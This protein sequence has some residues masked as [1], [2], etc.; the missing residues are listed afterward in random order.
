MNSVVAQDSGDGGSGDGGDSGDGGSGDGGDSG[1]GGSGDSGDGGSEPTP[2]PPE[3]PEGPEGGDGDGGE[4]EEVIVEVVNTA[5]TLSVP[6]Q[7]V[8]EDAG[9][10][11]NLIDLW[12]YV[13]D[14]ISTAANMVFSLVSQTASSVVSCSLDSNRYMDCATQGNQFGTSDVT[15]SVTDEGGLTSQDTFTID[16]QSVNDAPTVNINEPGSKV[17]EN[18]DFNF[19]A[20]ASDVEGDALTYTID[21]DDGT[22]EQGSVVSGTIQTTHRYEDEGRFTITITVSDGSATGSD[23]ITVKTITPISSDIHN[24]IYM[25][26]IAFDNEFVRPGD[27]LT[28]FLNFENQGSEDLKDVRITA[29]IQD[30]GVRSRTLSVDVN[31]NNGV[32]RTLTLEIPENAQEGRYWVEVVID[33]D[34]DRRVKFRPV[35]VV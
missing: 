24:I 2:P 21:F 28:M 7:T 32:S 30:L 26:S 29:I 4:E 22:I 27:E 35:D 25:G 11:D 10:L 5:P 9:V 31:D 34:G 14:D 17:T 18:E 13:V 6:D 19:V 16:V 15:V 1:D 23:S 12:N 3:P 33:I 8:N 20:T